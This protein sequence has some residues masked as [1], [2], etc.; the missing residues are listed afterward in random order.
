MSVATTF[1]N[2]FPTPYTE[3]K[4]ELCGTVVVT[5]DEGT[6]AMVGDNNFVKK[7]KTIEKAWFETKSGVTAWY[8]HTNSILYLY[9][10]DGTAYMENITLQFHITGRTL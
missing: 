10:T 2:K 1:V 6:E 7:F 3:G 8:D 4:G 9:A 5:G